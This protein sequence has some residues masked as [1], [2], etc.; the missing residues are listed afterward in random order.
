MPGRTYDPLCVGPEREIGERQRDVDAMAG[1]SSSSN[2][3]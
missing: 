2:S 1:E 3:V